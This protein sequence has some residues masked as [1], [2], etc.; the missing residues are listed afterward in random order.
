MALAAEVVQEGRSSTLDDLAD[1]LMSRL[2]PHGGYPDDV[3]LLLY[4]QP[5]PLAMTFTP[6]VGELAPTRDALRTWLTQAGVEPA[7]IADVLTATGEAVSNAIEHGHRDRPDGTVSLQATAWADRLKVTVTDGGR[8]RNPNP[9][10]DIR[11]GR[12]VGL[13]RG[14]MDDFTISTDD[15]GTTVELHARIT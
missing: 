12:G 1:H 15:V 9:I 3:A 13:M 7:Q 5:A 10:A 14:L 4:R 6:T 11:R 2:E 8:W